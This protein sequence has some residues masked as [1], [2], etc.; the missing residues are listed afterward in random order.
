MGAQP[1]KDENGPEKGDARAR[2]APME[3]WR[4]RAECRRAPFGECSPAGITPTR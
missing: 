2:F 3:R 4:W 1:G